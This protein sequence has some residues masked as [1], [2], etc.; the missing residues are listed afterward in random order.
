MSK[1]RKSSKKCNN[2]DGDNSEQIGSDSGDE[3]AKPSE[4]QHSI[5][6]ENSA[7]VKESQ[8]VDQYRE[9]TLPNSDN[10][11]NQPRQENDV[12]SSLSST[13]ESLQTNE[14]EAVKNAQKS[15]QRCE[16]GK[17]EKP[18]EMIPKD[19]NYDS[20]EKINDPSEQ[21]SDQSK[22][23]IVI[24]ESETKS[25]SNAID[26]AHTTSV[27]SRTNSAERDE[28]LLDDRSSQSQITSTV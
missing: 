26:K 12:D 10:Q 1:K 17:I 15:E 24:D 20:A 14:T 19:S 13:A 27:R 28:Q 7:V 22:C 18:N 2:N 4:E 8:E 21:L 11:S 6:T 3:M 16:D 9:E 25:D 23:Q 5:P